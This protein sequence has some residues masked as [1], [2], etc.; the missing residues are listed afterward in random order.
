MIV[1]ILATIVGVSWFII[2]PICGCCF[3]GEKL[4]EW[5]YRRSLR[6]LGVK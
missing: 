2:L 6:K 4:A 3:I 5:S 1:D